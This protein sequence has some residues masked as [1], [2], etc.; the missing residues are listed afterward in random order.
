MSSKRKS[1]KRQ[2][3][4]QLLSMKAFGQKKH[5]DKQL[6]N[7]R[8]IKSKIYSLGTMHE[9]LKIAVRFT[10][11]AKVHGCRFLEDAKPLVGQYLQERID[12]GKSA[13]TIETDASALSKLFQVERSEF[14]V[15]LPP[16]RREDITQH[17]S[18]DTWKGLFSEKNNQDF[19][20]LCRA[21]GM[22][23]HEI[24]A[25]RTED[26]TLESD[27]RVMIHV[28][29]GKGGRERNLEALSDA[30]WRL[31]EA[32][33]AEGREFV[34][35]RVPSHAPIHQYRAEYAREMY[36]RIAR[37]P[38]TLPRKERYCAKAERFGQEYDREA[39]RVVSENLGHSR[40]DVLMNYLR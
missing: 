6:N 10:D 25:L 20:D 4:D 17:R 28:V 12:A 13:W 38:A 19:V 16:R 15:E 31:A 2:A 36:E 11:W 18:K 37:D 8:P 22:R 40:V 39:L 3:V 9:Y 33:K 32:A 34:V 24:A 1:L 29:S 5:R 27:G 35:A 26:V 7:G 30:P 23:R 21:T 14:G